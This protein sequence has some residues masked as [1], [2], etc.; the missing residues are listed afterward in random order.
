[1]QFRSFRGREIVEASKD[2]QIR[3]L[4]DHESIKM[5]LRYIF[6]LVGLKSENLPSELQK[7]VLVE[8]IESEFGWMTPEEMKLAF[9]MAVAGQLDVE[10]NHFQNFSSVYFAAVANAYR[11]KRGAAL[12]EFNQKMLD[13]TTK[14]NPSD[15]EKKILFWGFVDQC[16]LKRWDDFA[17]GKSIH[18][19]SVGG[20]EHIF[21]TMEQLGFVLSVDD[22]NQ[23]MFSAKTQIN[24]EIQNE[25]PESRERAK[26]VRS[27]RESLE[28]GEL[29]FKQNQSLADITRRRCYE[30]TM[31]HFFQTF[32]RQN[33]DFRA[34]VEQIK[35]EQYEQ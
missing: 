29:A 8:F 9:R 18:W 17:A 5:S 11:E 13:M 24:F 12:V 35:N 25:K 27:L 19:P 28:M 7:M 16:L 32:K 22:K 6:T 2:T 34:I 26:I 15:D 30:L 23:I 3:N 1:M 10:I 21:R 33:T 4:T 31:E 14:P 20:I